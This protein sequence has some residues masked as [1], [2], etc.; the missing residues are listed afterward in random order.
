MDPIMAQ[1]SSKLK[2]AL[3]EKLRLETKQYA[4]NYMQQYTEMATILR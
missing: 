2:A 3:M 4:V 1:N